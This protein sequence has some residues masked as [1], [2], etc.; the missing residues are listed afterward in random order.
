MGLDGNY[1][2][3]IIIIQSL[4]DERYYIIIKIS[5]CYIQKDD[6][7]SSTNLLI[8]KYTKSYKYLNFIIIV[9]MMIKFKYIKFL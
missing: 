7:Y 6:I 5:I 1:F 8:A 4:L 9:L 2:N 3:I